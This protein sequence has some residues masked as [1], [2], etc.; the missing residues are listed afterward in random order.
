MT[1]TAVNAAGFRPLS[2]AAVFLF[3]VFVFAPDCPAILINGDTASRNDRFSSGFPGAPV[4]NTNLLA[5]VPYSANLNLT[6][7]GWDTASP[8]RGVA[9]ISP[10]Y[11]I[12]ARHYGIGS[13]LSFLGNDNQ[14]HTYDVSSTYALKSTGPADSSGN[15]ADLMIGKLST[16]VDTAKI[17]TYSVVTVPGLTSLPA[18]DYSSNSNLIANQGPPKTYM[19]PNAFEVALDQATQFYVGKELVVVG[20]SQQIGRNRISAVGSVYFGNGD[21][22]ASQ[23]S[24]TIGFAYDYDTVNGFSPDEAFLTGGDSG[25]PTFMVYNNQLTLLGDH[26]GVDNTNL[27]SVDHFLPFYLDQINA[28]MAADNQSV[29]VIPVPEPRCALAFCAAVVLGAA[30]LR[31]RTRRAA[32]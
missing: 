7:V 24:T 3:A 4:T 21:P 20:Q 29:T 13:Q 31:G 27:I 15:Y 10:Q 12:F 22:L 2:A 32:A 18:Y 16:T 9:L 1:S 23:D 17:A 19:P 30:V 11:F 25:S 26:M 8:S 6:G 28:I 14:V 5:G